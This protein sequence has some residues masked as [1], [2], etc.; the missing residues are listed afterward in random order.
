MTKRGDGVR[1]RIDPIAN[2]FA[3]SS[4]IIFVFSFQVDDQDVGVELEG[5]VADH[6]DAVAGSTLQVF[7]DPVDKVVVSLERVDVVDDF[8]TFQQL[9][10][11][12]SDSVDLAGF[13]ADLVLRVD[14]PLKDGDL[15]VDRNGGDVDDLGP[16]V[17]VGCRHLEVDV[18]N[19]AVVVGLKRIQRWLNPKLYKFRTLFK[20]LFIFGPSF[21]PIKLNEPT[22]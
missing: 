13:L 9:S 12:S 17:D 10:V 4:S 21:Y 1:E 19:A 3:I 18:V 5:V 7:V 15:F 22:I 2:S 6:P 8:S 14:E 16:L 20:I 11:F